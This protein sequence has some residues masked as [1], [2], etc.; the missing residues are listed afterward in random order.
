MFYQITSIINQSGF[1]KDRYIG[2]T[3]RSI[4][5]LMY[6]TLKENIPGLMIFIDFNKAI[7]SVE[8]NYLVTCLE[9]FRFGP[10]FI[11]WVKTLFKKIQSGVINNGLTTGYFPLERVVRQGDPLSRYLFVCVVETIRQNTAIKDIL[12]G[13]EETKLLQYADDTT[14][15]LLSDR[16]SAHAFFDRHNV[17]WKLSGLKIIT[18]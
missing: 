16:D 2:E 6:F 4:L 18:S 7:D 5:D 11:R 3:V 15:V 9:A 12:I 14:A 13:K 1:V 17:F 8:W 10:D